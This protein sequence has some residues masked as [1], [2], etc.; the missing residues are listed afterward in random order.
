MWR[1]RYSPLAQ[2]IVPVPQ[3]RQVFLSDVV[4]YFEENKHALAELTVIYNISKSAPFLDWQYPAGITWGEQSP[5]NF[6]Y[7]MYTN[8][9]WGSFYGYVMSENILGSS[10]D[11][12][13]GGMTQ[14]TVKYTVIGMTYWMQGQRDKL[15][16]QCNPSSIARDIA[17]TYGMRAVTE[18]LG[19]SFE[20]QMQSSQSDWKFL[21]DTVAQRI[22]A[23]LSMDGASTLYFTQYTTPIPSS[24]GTWPVF[25]LTKKSGVIDTLHE[26]Q[27]ITG[28]TDP[29]GGYRLNQIATAT[30]PS[31]PRVT[32]SPQRDLDV[33]RPVQ[34]FMKRY[35]LWPGRSYTEMEQYLVADSEPLWMYAEATTD[36]DPRCKVGGLVE[37]QG[38]GVAI[39]HRGKWI[40]RSAT[41]R[42]HQV[43]GQPRLN[44]YT[45]D[46]KLGRNQPNRLAEPASPLNIGTDHGTVLVGQRWRARYSTPMSGAS[47]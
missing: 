32:F 22:S 14:V 5:V 20:T 6:V 47:S 8:D 19:V 11:P 4:I 44:T 16:K 25:T 38:A 18:P 41:H 28:D 2:I 36:G 10:S 26:F 15:W 24:N 30:S 12:R 46:L 23:R 27:G 13:Y 42:I 9:V 17:N 45:C 3:D 37:V 7:R 21:A 1:R 33:I 35:T 34:T 40:I 31:M 39:D 43:I 29:V